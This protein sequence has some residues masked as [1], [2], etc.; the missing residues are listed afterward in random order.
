MRTFVVIGFF[1]LCSGSLF[2][3]NT[4]F[5]NPLNIPWSF[6]A[7]FSELRANAFH[8]GVDFRTQQRE[9]L[10]IF[11]VADG[12]LSRV[13]VSATG[14][15]KALYI[16]HTDGIMSVYAHLQKFI[17]SIETIVKEQHYAK[18]SFEL[19]LNPFPEKIQFK[20]GDL[21][22]YS[23]NTG[24]S[25]GPHLHFEIR[26]KGGEN[27]LNPERFGYTVR[28]HIPPTISTFAIYPHG[29]R[30][31]VNGQQTPL[32]L[33]VR[34]RNANC[35][36]SDTIRVFGDFAFGIEATDK[37]NDAPNILGLHRKKLFID[38]ELKFA[39]RLDEMPFSHVRF[40]NAFIDYAHLDSTGKRIQWTY[41]L[42]GNRLNIYEKTDGRGVY[43]FVENGVRN[44]RI[45]TADFTGN[46]SVLNVVLLV[47][48]EMIF[49]ESMSDDSAEL[50]N[51]AA[52]EI[53][54]SPNNISEHR[55]FSHAVS[56]TFET[57]EI[58]ITIPANAL[59]KP[60]YLEYQ[61]DTSFN[62]QVFS[63][64]H[65]VHHSGTP[66]HTNYSLSIKPKNLPENLE[67]KALIGSW[68]RKKN[69]WIAEGGRFENGFVL[70]NIRKF[71]IFAVCMDTINPTIRPVNVQNNRIPS[72]QNLLTFRIDDDFSG[73][74]SYRATIN[75]RWFL[76]E[77]DAKTKTLKGT[78]DNTLQKG[79]HDFKLTVTD[80]KNNSTTYHAKIIR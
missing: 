47:D 52:T 17:P 19:N 79:E 20:K 68:D 64:I 25:G 24:S 4:T 38:D 73:I 2:T 67:N 12:F 23:G 61:V 45:E 16:S 58:K 59:Y 74:E 65:H 43:S 10:P 9:G 60:I 22:G 11:A 63:D 48:D 21:I 15:G 49:E 40:I 44:L 13:V 14:Y 30:S 39:W 80:R 42:P 6:S 57:N 5:G 29:N 33:P 72:S 69:E 70:H 53:E 31:L 1:L 3:Q 50:R 34:C 71:G 66:V 54:F 51:S 75:E 37:A 18:E 55:L 26:N 78:I 8:A 62:S 36:V 7:S 76:M 35:L 32:Q 27:A 41:I 28:D 77:Y 46:T 56:N